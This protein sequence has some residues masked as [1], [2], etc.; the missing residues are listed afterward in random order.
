M[1]KALGPVDKFKENQVVIIPNDLSSIG[2]V[3]IGSEI[4]AYENNCTHDGEELGRCRVYG[5]EIECPRHGA[6]FDVRTGQAVRMPAVGN[7]ETYPVSIQ[8]GQVYAEID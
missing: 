7:L 1:K 5:F 6:R 3:K 2:V 4:F 8:D